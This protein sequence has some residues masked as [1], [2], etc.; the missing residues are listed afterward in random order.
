M[1]CQSNSFLPGSKR[2]STIIGLQ[3]QL[4]VVSVAAE[5]LYLTVNLYKSKMMLFK[6]KGVGGGGGLLGGKRNM[7]LGGAL[8]QVV[9][10]KTA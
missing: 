2:A 9:W 3:N 10:R 7:F 6:K 5:I 8:Y 4:N 1:Y